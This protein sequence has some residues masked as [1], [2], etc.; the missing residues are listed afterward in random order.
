MSRFLAWGNLLLFG[1][2]GVA[3]LMGW[4]I[5]EDP[6]CIGRFHVDT[7]A[8]LQ[9]EIGSGKLAVLLFVSGFAGYVWYMSPA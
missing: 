1:G 5:P 9:E 4:T 8:W 7:M 3:V 2:L 6:D